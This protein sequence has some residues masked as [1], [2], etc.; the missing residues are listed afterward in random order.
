MFKFVPNFWF[1]WLLF[2]HAAAQSRYICR[3]TLE[4]LF[5]N[6]MYL[7]GPEIQGVR[8]KKWNNSVNF[9]LFFILSFAHERWNSKVFF[10]FY[11]HGIYPPSASTTSWSLLRN[12]LHDVRITFWLRLPHARFRSFFRSSNYVC[13]LAQA[14]T[15][16]MLHTQYSSGFE[17][18]N[19]E[20]HCSCKMNA[21]TFPFNQFCVALTLCDGAES[22]ILL[23]CPALR[24]KLFAC[25]R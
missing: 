18:G 25:S 15:F 1:L 7:P 21:G 16:K 22:C 19:D 20:G 2:I 17:S 9:Q 11:S 10:T 8:I 13:F 6:T 23:E 3:L 24:T 12:D 4:S 5:W 14:L